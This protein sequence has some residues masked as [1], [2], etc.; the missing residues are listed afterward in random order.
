MLSK[1]AKYALKALEYIAGKGGDEPLLIAEIAREQHIP[2]KFLEV[3]LLELKKDGV[4]RSKMGKNG[5]Y[6]LQLTT[7]EIKLGHIIRLMDGAIALVPCVSFKYYTPCEECIDEATCGLRNVM[8]ELREAT[9]KILDNVTLAEVLRREKKLS[10]GT[11]KKTN[12]SKL[13]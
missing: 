12:S 2:R 13:Q 4:L 8:A 11:R 1:K 6:M 9:N 7:E 10:K 5:G 3:I